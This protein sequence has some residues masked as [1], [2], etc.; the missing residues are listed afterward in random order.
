METVGDHDISIEMKDL[1]V[2]TYAVRLTAGGKS[3][4]GVIDLI[5]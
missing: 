2:G 5:K 1:P 4:I 3:S